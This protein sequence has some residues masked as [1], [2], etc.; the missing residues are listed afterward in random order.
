M[1]MNVA[2]VKN[3]NAFEEI[4]KVQ[5]LINKRKET[6]FNRLMFSKRG[7]SSFNRKKRNSK[8]RMLN[9]ENRT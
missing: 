5:N 7:S 1:V 2:I 9:L 4:A 3:A 8:S 6:Q